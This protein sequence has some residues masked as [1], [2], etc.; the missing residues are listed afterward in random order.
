MQEAVKGIKLGDKYRKTQLTMGI[1]FIVVGVFGLAAG[2]GVG[3][4]LG[5]GI[6]NIIISTS[7]KEKD[8]IK[9]FDDY[10]EVKLAP[11]AVRRYIKTKDIIKVDTSNA[12]YFTVFFKFDDKE[13]K[14]KF[15]RSMFNEDDYNYLS[16]YFNPKEIAA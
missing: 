13:K 15:P 6:L 11:L 3:G 10:S 4:L 8:A 12:K 2:T 9:I 5:I 1:L 7:A 16:E 14:Q